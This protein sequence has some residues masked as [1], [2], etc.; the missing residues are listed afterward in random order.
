MDTLVSTPATFGQEHFGDAPLG[1]R[2]RVQRLVATADLFAAHP[3]GSLP[4][5][6]RDPAAYQGLMRLARHPSVTHETVLH[7][8]RQRTQERMR[9]TAVVLLLHD[10]TEL[11]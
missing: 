5:K 1:H 7:S 4:D 9:Q 6:L 11:D 3:A 8:H 10:G 2:R